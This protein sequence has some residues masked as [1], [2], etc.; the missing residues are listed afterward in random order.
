VDG[1]NPNAPAILYS[2]HLIA[3]YTSP[4]KHVKAPPL[5][6]KIPPLVKWREYKRM[7]NEEIV[8]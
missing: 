5:L 4:L 7:E 3:T 1:T 2:T 8:E 6:A